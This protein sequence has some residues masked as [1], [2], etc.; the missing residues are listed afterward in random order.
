MPSTSA[1]ID[2]I[3]N[4]LWDMFLINLIVVGEVPELNTDLTLASPIDYNNYN[5]SI[6]I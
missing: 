1:D 2:F 6:P 4:K 5:T 3:T